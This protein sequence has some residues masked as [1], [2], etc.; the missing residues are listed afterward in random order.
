[1]RGV[2]LLRTAVEL[3]VEDVI[4]CAAGPGKHST[5]FLSKGKNVIGIDLKPSGLTHQNYRHIQESFEDVELDPVDLVW[6][7]HTSVHRLFE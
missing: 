2:R 7:C 3:D 5:A 6:S 1:M 4:D